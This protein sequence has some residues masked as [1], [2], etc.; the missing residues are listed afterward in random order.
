MWWVIAQIPLLTIAIV[1]PVAQVML[2][3]QGPWIGPLELPARVLGVALIAV[4]T[5]VFRG[6]QREL[7]PE[8]VATPMPTSGAILRV[9]G[10]YATVRHPIYVAVVSGVTG[11]ALAWNSVVGLGLGAGCSLFFLAK[12]R[13]EETL[14]VHSFPG[15]QEYRKRVPR[16]VPRI[17]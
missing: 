13:Y 16:F 10:I 2:R 4:A 11:W 12:S 14:L 17:R 7:G 5:L 15:Y 9:S 3:V 6:A 8:L 1:V